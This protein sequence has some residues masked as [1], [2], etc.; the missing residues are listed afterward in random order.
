CYVSICHQFILIWHLISIVCNLFR[1][2]VGYTN[3]VESWN[4][5][6]LKVRDLIIH[7]FI[8]E[9][10]RINSEMSYMYREKAEISQAHITPGL[11][12]TMTSY[13]RTDSVNIKDDTCS[14]RWWQMMGIP[15]ED[16]VRILGLANVDPTTRVFE[17]FTNDTYKV[18]FKPIWIPIRGIEQWIILIADLR[19]RAL[20]PTV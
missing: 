15:C 7:V 1:Y 16:E 13:G 2:R 10:C 20:I 17:Y 9:L 19:V 3:H 5:I 6:I 11:Q 12:I 18:I 8:K 4:N 14:C